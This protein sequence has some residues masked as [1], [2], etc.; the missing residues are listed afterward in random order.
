VYTAGMAAF[1]V[2][3]ILDHPARLLLH[4][5]MIPITG[6]FLRSLGLGHS[7]FASLSIS[8]SSCLSI[9]ISSYLVNQAYDP[10]L[11][12]RN[13]LC[14]DGPSHPPRPGEIEVNTRLTI[15]DPNLAS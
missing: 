11:L 12:A 9:F 13:R 4:T 8:L 2:L 5:C 10:G 3:M 1:L 14:N 15:A 6:A 7:L